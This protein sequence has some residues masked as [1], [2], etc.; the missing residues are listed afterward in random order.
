MGA[1][2]GRGGVV[3]DQAQE[4]V[5]LQR[6][7]AAE[8]LPFVARAAR[9]D[10]TG[11]AEDAQ[12][13]ARRGGWLLCEAGKT[14]AGFTVIERDGGLFI[15][16]ASGEGRRDLTDCILGLLEQAGAASVAFQTRRPGLIRKAAR[17]GYRVEGE[18]AN[19]VIMRKACK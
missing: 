6:A 16:A 1:G 8:I 13:V 15:T 19:G 10:T 4:K 5:T 9:Y 11:G 7:T 14:I 18:V 2:G 12:S 3:V 17:R